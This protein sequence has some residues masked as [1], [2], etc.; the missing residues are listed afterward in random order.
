MHHGSELVVVAT[1]CAVLLVGLFTRTLS[2]RTRLPYTVLVLLVGL[3]V[4]LLLPE[5][6]LVA[7][8]DQ[9]SPDLILFV[10]LP[11]LVFESAFSMHL[12]SVRRNVGPV[13]WL[14]IPALLVSTAG[15]AA[16]MVAFTSV[17]WQ[18]GWTA[19]LVF[20]A[21]ISA[22]DPVA[23][24]AL[25]RELG[26]PKRISTLIE[27]E[28]LFNDGTAIV[29]FS[30]LLGILSGHAAFDPVETLVRFGVV[31]GGGVA[32]G[33]VAGALTSLWLSRVFNQAVVEITLTLALAYTCMVVA[34][35][36][37]V[38]GVMAVVVAGLWMSGPGRVHISPEVHHFL[39][40][41]WQVLA[42][43]ANTLIFFLVGLVVAE[44]IGDA[45]P[46]DLVVVAGSFVG[47]V[48]LRMAIVFASRPVFALVSEPVSAGE[49]AVMG[50]GGLRGAVSL[51]LALI[52]AKEH[53]VPEPIREQMLLLTAGVVLGTLVVNGTTV[54]LLLHRLGFDRAP[55]PDRLAQASTHA[56]LLESVTRRVEAARNDPQLRTV[57]WADVEAELAQRRAEVEQERA[58]ARAELVS[59]PETAAVGAWRQALSIERTGY[60]DAFAHGTLDGR[61]VPIL[62]ADVDEQLHRLAQTGAVPD[63]T[64]IIG[65]PGWRGVLEQWLHKPGRTLRWLQFDLLAMRY[66]LARAQG[67]A[68]AA[69]LDAID[70]GQVQD[71]GVNAFYRDW[72]HQATEVLEDF[73]ANLPE[74]T[75]ALETRIARRISLN[76]EREAVGRLE[77]R[78]AI[79]PETAARTRQNIEQRMKGLAQSPRTVSLPDTTAVCRNAPLFAGLAPQEVARIAELTTEKA[80]SPDE[81]L[82]EQGTTGGNLFIVARGAVAILR[83]EDGDT[84]LLDILGS[85]DVL[86]EMELL[87]G[88][89][90]TATIRALTTCLVGEIDRE[91][92][93]ALMDEI[94]A[95]AQRIREAFVRRRFDNF[96][97]GLPAFSS[98]GHGQR[99]AWF[100]RG[101]HHSLRDG[102]HAPSDPALFVA[103]GA[104]QGWATYAAPA[105]VRPRD[106]ETLVAVGVTE[107]VGLPQR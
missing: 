10:F 56:S 11:I 21:L 35:S 78:G 67:L 46:I 88:Q 80:L 107:V 75:A 16:W 66:E 9:V 43:I 31:A 2:H 98:L 94:P 92:F 26:A 40:H 14:A 54:G 48:A 8:G 71:D 101:E 61:A 19:A 83:E 49:A 1:L 62:D 84:R 55:A 86:G 77:S 103:T 81:V 41:F 44:S 82:F 29:V 87:T 99:M 25:L 34:E 70:Q 59:H 39:H 15:V 65:L 47:I 102:A 4:G 32:I 63:R 33:V 90:R 13:L 45:G 96:V 5:Q 51:A 85:G 74:M 30:L 7:T 27:G 37:H 76:L 93:E 104:L 24:V 97:R 105:L 60:W 91:G 52:V 6:S 53:G 12:H 106:D 57:A 22:T 68:A 72:K 36:L 95:V 38:S 79:D 23:V 18:W 50:W 64:R 42:S 100:D 73:R 17:S 28:S 20:G 3:V 69:V 89:P 58:A